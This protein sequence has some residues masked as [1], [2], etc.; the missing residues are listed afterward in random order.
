M[1]PN[2]QRASMRR[3]AIRLATI[4]ASVLFLSG[5]ASAHVMPWREGMSRQTGFG[6]CAKGPCLKRT[7]FSPTVPHVH[8]AVNGRDSVVLC[9]GL[10]RKPNA[11]STYAARW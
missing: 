6:T 7:D 5:Q 8:L 10:K 11:C 3:S 1:E 2:T 9:T 4:A